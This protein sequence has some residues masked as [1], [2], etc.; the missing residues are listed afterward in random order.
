MKYPL[1]SS[2]KTS[3]LYHF[4]AFG[5]LGLSFKTNA[6]EALSFGLGVSSKRV[7][8]VDTHNGSITKSIVVGPIGGIY[9]DRNN[10]CS[11]RM[12]SAIVF[13]ISFDSIYT[14]EFFIYSQFPRKYLHPLA[15]KEAVCLV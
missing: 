10:S 4:G 14:Q 11:H 12:F 7:Y 13:M 2:G 8:T 1:T 9:W 15:K 3:L 5:M 6:E